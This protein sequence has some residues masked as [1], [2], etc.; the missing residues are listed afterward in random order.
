[1][2]SLTIRGEQVLTVGLSEH[3]GMHI[4]IFNPKGDGKDKCKLTI[5]D[6]EFWSS[7]E[8]NSIFRLVSTGVDMSSGIT[9]NTSV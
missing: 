9:S 6:Q 7:L 3:L 1:M 2:Q 8:R 5:E 4:E